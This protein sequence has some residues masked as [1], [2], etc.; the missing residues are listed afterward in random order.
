MFVVQLTQNQLLDTS[1]LSS[2]TLFFML[3]NDDDIRTVGL[4]PFGDILVHPSTVCFRWSPRPAVSLSTI[5]VA[6]TLPAHNVSGS[7]SVNRGQWPT[8]SDW[9]LNDR[10][11][12]DN[13][14]ISNAPCG[15]MLMLM[16][17]CMSMSMPAYVNTDRVDTN[18]SETL[19]CI[20]FTDTTDGMVWVN[21]LLYVCMYQAPPLPCLL[22]MGLRRGGKA[23]PK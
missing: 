22:D 2:P 6:I 14:I 18:S 4:A 3:C 9:C 12:S 17:M 19:L 8:V 13:K 16:S 23:T 20:V 10:E 21:K 1:D 5:G 15:D 11:I 7:R